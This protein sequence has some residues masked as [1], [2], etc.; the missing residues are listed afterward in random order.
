[1]GRIRLFGREITGRQGDAR[2]YWLMPRRRHAATRRAGP[3][4]DHPIPAAS[5]LPRMPRSP[6][7]RYGFPAATRETTLA[8][9]RFP[10]EQTGQDL[11]RL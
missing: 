9:G 5:T 2:W 7:R 1:M 6:G 11:T 3:S 8:P 4:P 10:A